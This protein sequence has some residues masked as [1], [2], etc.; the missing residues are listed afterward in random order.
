M[1]FIYPKTIASLPLSLM[2]LAFA[3]SAHA[4]MGPGAGLGMIGS[5]IAIIVA[6]LVVVLGLIIYPIRLF[7]KHL[8]RSAK[9]EEK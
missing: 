1:E 8:R 2:L 9:P 6:G 5:L 4:Y 3:D 7:M